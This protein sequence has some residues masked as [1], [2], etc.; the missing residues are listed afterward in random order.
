MLFEKRSLDIHRSIRDF[1]S[2]IIEQRTSI[3]HGTVVSSSRISASMELEV[4]VG[5]LAPLV[6]D[7]TLGEAL[8]TCG[9][10]TAVQVFRDASGLRCAAAETGA[11]W[12]PPRL[13]FS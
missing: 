3:A 7:N 4:Q 13:L 8:S 5:G 9:T 6:D 12:P 10:V 2:T 1:R 11:L